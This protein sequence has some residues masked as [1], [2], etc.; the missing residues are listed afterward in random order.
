MDTAIDRLV[1][2]HQDH[3]TPAADGPSPPSRVAL[4]TCMDW[5]V[6]PHRFLGAAADGIHVLRNA[7]GLVTEDVLRSLA[8]SQAVLGTREIM[9]VMHDASVARAEERAL[10][11]RVA[12][13][14]AT[15]PTVAFGGFD[16]L[17]ERVRESVRAVEETPWIPHRDQVRG[18]VLDLATG[19]LREVA[20]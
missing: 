12:T 11:E 13:A 8:L 2:G 6:Q 4:V 5:R 7:G 16:D 15:T 10:R 18:F 1:A 17:D 19:R 3:V 20:S 14:T 9:I